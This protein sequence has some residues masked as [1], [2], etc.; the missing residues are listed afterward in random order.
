M[1]RQTRKTNERR[2]PG[3]SRPTGERAISNPGFAWALG[4]FLVVTIAFF[5]G[6]LSGHVFLWEDFAEFTFPN[7]VFAARSFMSGTLP[8]WN[9]FT[10][11]GMPFLADLQI[12]FFYPG[13]LLM[14]LFSGGALSSWLEQFFLI[15]HYPIAMIA[16]WTLARGFGI[17]GWGAIFAGI[18]YAL[19]GVLVAHMIH[20]NL[21]EHLAWFPLIVYLFYRALGERSLLFSLLSGILLGLVFLAGHPQSALYIVFFLFCLTIFVLIRDARKENG[22]RGRAIISTALLAL[23]P[24]LLGAGI[25]AVQLLP[26]QELAGLSERATISYEKS[27]EGAMHAPQLL[28]LVVPKLFGESSA[29]PDTTIPYWYGE[30]FYYWETAVYLGVVSL[31][32]LVIGVGTKRLGALGWFFLGMALFGLLYGLGNDFFIHRLVNQLPLFGTF[33]SPVRMAMFFALGGALLA[34]AGL[35]RVVRSDRG[36]DVMKLAFWSGGVIAVLA[37][38][39]AV[40]VIPAMVNVPANERGAIAA[41]GTAPLLLALAALG[42]IW[43]AVRK[44]LTATGSALALILL[45]V[46]DLFIFGVGQNA[47]PTDP[48]QSYEYYDQQFAAFKADPPAKIF[49][50]RMRNEYGMLMKRNQGPYSGIMLFEGYNPLLLERRVP[51]AATPDKAYDLMDVRYTIAAD[52][53]RRSLGVVERPSAYPHARLMYDSR[54]GSSEEV[55]RWLKDPSIDLGRTVLLEREPEPAP[56][57]SGGHGSARIT[58]YSPERIDVAVTTDR[59]AILLLSEVWYPA[60]KGSI[61]GHPQDIMIGDHSLR[62]IPVPAGTHTVTMVYRSSAFSTGAWISIV[63]LLLSIGGVG[64]LLLRRGRNREE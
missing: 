64:V 26:S 45:G 3:G 7:E 29:Q 58:H 15:L 19:S 6:H 49:R 62:A 11:C 30:S 51:P 27:L 32:L 43:A 13:N 17:R 21:L 25:F 59:T 35:D 44:G 24:I 23:L 14:Y 12:G 28:T 16:M 54:V 8:F 61:D 52:T 55:L 1:S 46:I 47:S 4:I 41:T 34:G 57:G 60:W 37:L 5:W 2:N 40:G 18:T 20:V 53:A 38:L 48:Q 22:S 10:F 39:T 36:S 9:P 56:A 31:I 42:V 63:A 33:R 50:L